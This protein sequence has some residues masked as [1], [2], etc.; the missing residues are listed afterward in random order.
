MNILKKIV[1]NKKLEINFD[2]QKYSF[3][4]LEKLIQNYSNRGFKKLLKNSNQS[5]KNNIIG[6]IKKASPSAGEIIHDYDPIKIAKK[7]NESGIKALSI[8]TDK[9]FFQ[10]D[11]EHITLVNNKIKLPI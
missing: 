5:K 10:G 4:T 9:K 7:Y 3:G 11:I 1:E 8:L 2:K 6:E